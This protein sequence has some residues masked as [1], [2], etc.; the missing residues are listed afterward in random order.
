MKNSLNNMV[1]FMDAQSNMMEVSPSDV[2]TP[3]EQQ[4]AYNRIT[5]AAE[6][7]LLAKVFSKNGQSA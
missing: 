6:A 2:L 7:I 5:M 4:M 3:N 1:Y